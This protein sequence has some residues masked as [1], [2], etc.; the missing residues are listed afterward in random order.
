M[1]IL[2]LSCGNFYDFAKSSTLRFF[3]PSQL[4]NGKE[5]IVIPGMQARCYRVDVLALLHQ[6]NPL[7]AVKRLPLPPKSGCQMVPAATVEKQ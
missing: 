2:L 6:D 1:K 3:P 5:R 4:S 7:G